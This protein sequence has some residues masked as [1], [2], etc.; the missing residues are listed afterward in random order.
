MESSPSVATVPT[1]E[2]SVIQNHHEDL[3][4]VII[5]PLQIASKLVQ[6]GVVGQ[7]VVSEVSTHGRSQLQN[8]ITI[9]TAVTAS[10]HSEPNQFQ[11]FMSVLEETPESAHLARK[12]R[13]KLSKS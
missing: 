6:E 11:V 7:T 13:D 4:Q 2:E 1:A 12:L 10:I 3:R 9:I 5:H 8:S